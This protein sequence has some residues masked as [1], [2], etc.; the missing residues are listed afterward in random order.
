M[1][2]TEFSSMPV[3]M[4]NGVYTSPWPFDSI[5]GGAMANINFQD[6]SSV[7]CANCHTSINHI[8]PLFANFDMNGMYQSTIQVM[9][10]IKGNP[11]TKPTDWLPM[12]EQTSWRLGTAVSDTNQLGQA[13]AK[14][15]AVQSCMVMRVYNWAMSK[16]DPVT[17]LA[18]VPDQVLQPYVQV[19]TSN[20]TKFKPTIRAAFVSDDFVKF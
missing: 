5:S 20:G 17:D 18:V 15:P 2:P 11:N 13:M 16:D 1:F 12:G 6:T 4:G 10:P 8:A 14:D 9:T 7:I 3:A 19:F